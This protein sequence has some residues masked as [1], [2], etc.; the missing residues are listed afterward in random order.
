VATGEPFIASSA[1][2][3]GIADADMIHAFCNPVLV[4]HID[5]GLT[6]FIGGDRAAN[7]LEVG[8]VDSSDGPIIVHAMTARPHYPR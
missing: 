5:E 6:M 7:T 2:R 4:D 1:R 3:H 8:V